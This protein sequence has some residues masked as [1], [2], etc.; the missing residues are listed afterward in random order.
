MVPRALDRYGLV[1]AV[2]TA[3]GVRRSRLHFPGGPV[4]DLAGVALGLRAAA[5]TVPT[6]EASQRSRKRTSAR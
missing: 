4:S 2:L 1:V 3:D 5:A 6:T